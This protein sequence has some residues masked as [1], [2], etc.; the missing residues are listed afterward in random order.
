MASADV[1]VIKRLVANDSRTLRVINIW[2]T[3]CGPCLTEFSGLVE[4]YRRFQNHPFEFITISVD[5][6]AQQ[7]QV[8][9]FLQEQ[10]AAVAKRT[11]RILKK[12]GRKTNNLIFTGDD[13]E[14][15]ATVLDPRWTGAQP[16][17]LLVAPGGEVLFRQT[18]KID[19]ESLQAAI[20]KYVR[21]NFLK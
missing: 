11:E 14:E 5:S 8:A 1:L 7:E 3:S 19:L 10:H 12:T 13:L 21:A 18:G 17:T 2:S 16:H 20:V 15:M 9:S 4:T 6:P